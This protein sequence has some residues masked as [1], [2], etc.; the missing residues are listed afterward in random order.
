MNFLNNS[1]IDK[2]VSFLSNHSRKND[3]LLISLHSDELTAVNSA[4]D[5]C[6]IS[7]YFDFLY[8]KYREKI[9]GLPSRFI[10]YKHNTCF[11]PNRIFTDVGRELILNSFQFLNS[12]EQKDFMNFTSEISSLITNI[13][14]KYKVIIA[15][16][17][18]SGLDYSLR[19]YLPFGK[20]YND[21]KD[22]FFIDKNNTSD[23][24]LVT[25]EK[26]YNLIILEKK[27]NVILQN[28][29]KACDDGSL[30]IYC[31][32]NNIPY[33]NLE[34]MQHRYTQNKKMLLFIKDVL[35]QKINIDISS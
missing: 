16:H 23:F 21:C 13:I 1:F 11:D 27:Y 6:N 9:G 3:I 17:N 20:F 34:V 2:Y 14:I 35:V 33:I 18:N 31:G 5:V 7:P 8:F 22:I 24:F 29:E 15:V 19:N 28:N 12:S 30:S 32:K 26:I 4:L 25:D 10:E